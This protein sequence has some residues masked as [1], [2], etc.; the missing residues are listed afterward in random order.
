MVDILQSRDRRPSYTDRILISSIST[1]L[2]ILEYST[3]N[4]IKLSDHRPVYADI[5]LVQ[6][7]EDNQI[8][9]KSVIYFSCSIFR[10]RRKN[11]IK[12]N[13]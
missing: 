10:C 8:P 7:S 2:K 4:N 13:L 3:L 11:Q 1:N 9:V 12:Q 5:L 6:Q